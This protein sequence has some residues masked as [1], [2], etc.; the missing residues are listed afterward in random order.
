MY[1]GQVTQELMTQIAQTFARNDIE[2]IVECFT[3][4]GIFINGKGPTVEGDTYRGKDEIRA[5][6]TQLFTHGTSIRWD[7]V[8]TDWICGD[9]AVTQW[10]R[11][12]DLPDGSRSEWFGCDLYMF[13]GSKIKR[14]DT[15]VK[16]VT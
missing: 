7:R 12:A 10:H 8:Q 5:F 2:G 4:D 16:I 9:R 6:F 11:K 1:Q 13:E 15:F 14:K 3:D